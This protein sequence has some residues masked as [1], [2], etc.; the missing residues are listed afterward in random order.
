MGVWLAEAD[1]LV[2]LCAE[3]RDAAVARARMVKC[4]LGAVNGV[5]FCRKS[6]NLVEG[7]IAKVI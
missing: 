6:E 3:A 1:A 4:I 5:S 7:N 2:E